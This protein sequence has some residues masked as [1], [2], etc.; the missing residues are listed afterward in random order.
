MRLLGFDRKTKAARVQVTSANDLWALEV[1]L[2]RGDI[3]TARTTRMLKSPDGTERGE[4]VQTTLSVS[5]EKTVFEPFV[6]ALRVTGRVVDDPDDLGVLGSY[7]TL[8]VETGSI[9]TITKDE[10]LDEELEELGREALGGEVVIVAVDYEEV[11]LA[12]LWDYGVQI[13][14]SW[15]LSKPRKEDLKD[16]ERFERQ[17][18]KISEELLGHISP[19]TFLIVAGPGYL[20]QKVLEGLKSRLSANGV[21]FESTLVDTEYGGVS[22]VK[23]AVNKAVDAGFLKKLRVARESEVVDTLFREISRDEAKVAVGLDA[24]K[25]AAENGA[26]E[27]L[28]VSS[29]LLKSSYSLLKPVMRAVEKYG[30]R[31]E[32]VSDHHEKGEQL[33][34]LG[35]VAAILRYPIRGYS[36]S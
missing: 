6:N 22:G 21:S 20:K 29:R 2:N 26:V 35:G 12:K 15:R 17:V 24:V 7:H 28:I 25:S 32:V 19:N 1:L 9:I 33:A 3:V 36:S 10:W 23:Q 16:Q 4:R 31:V 30:G 13:V 18:E 11:A 8:V 14:S 34:G 27:L 5:V